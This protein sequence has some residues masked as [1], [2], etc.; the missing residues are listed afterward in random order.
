MSS[1]F[2]QL[3]S[4][5]TQSSPNVSW[6]KPGPLAYF[7][8][9]PRGFAQETLHPSCAVEVT[10]GIWMGAGAKTLRIF[11][12]ALGYSTAPV[13]CRSTPTRLIDSIFNDALR[14]VTGCLAHSPKEDL[15][16]L[17][18]IQLAELRRLGATLF[19]ANRAIHDLPYTAQTVGWAAGCAPG[20]T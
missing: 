6:G 16:D 17:A 12:L 9:P 3:L 10:C 15:P 7:P 18:G 5:A 1:M 8:S 13:R 20:E 11:V 19:L 14:I 2:Q 4:I